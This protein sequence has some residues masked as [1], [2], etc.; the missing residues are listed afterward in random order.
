MKLE[1]STITKKIEIFS[2]RWFF[3][4][5]LLFGM[6]LISLSYTSDLMKFGEAIAR[7]FKSISL[8]I[9]ASVIASA[10]FYYLYS[11]T[12]ESRVIESV[13]ERTSQAAISYAYEV[14]YSHFKNVVPK[15]TY[16]K[17]TIP[18]LEFKED[19]SKSLASS[20][21]YRYKGDA[22]TFTI[23]RLSSLANNPV[24]QSKEISLIL[25]DP[26]AGLQL[27]ARARQE[28]IDSNASPTR[29]ELQDYADNI[30]ERIYSG[31]V[32]LYDI[33]H[34]LNTRVYFHDDDIFF[35]GEL[36]DNSIYIS[37]YLGGEFPGTYLYMNDTY[38]YKAFS[39]NFSQSMSTSK[40][41]IDFDGSMSEEEF[42]KELES[43]GCLIPLPELRKSRWKTNEKLRQQAPFPNNGLF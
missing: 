6:V 31:L 26:Q 32:A 28:L 17:S 10:L 20:Q 14:F 1:S 39:M 38:V 35:R 9:G 34:I 43:I 40:K 33:G 3:T 25:L 22:G 41:R 30:K 29:E 24:M 12:I 7:E 18:L 15:K 21:Y 19:F 36:F 42:T 4:V 5:A 16:P 11:R 13:A 37:Y 8:A 23:F 27:L 2:Q